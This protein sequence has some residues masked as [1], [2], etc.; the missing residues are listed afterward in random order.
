MMIC[1]SIFLPIPI[2]MCLHCGLDLSACRYLLVTH[3]HTDHF[4][5]TDLLMRI[6]GVFAHDLTQETITIA[7][8]EAVLS[9][10]EHYK[11]FYKEDPREIR[12]YIR[13]VPLHADTAR[14]LHGHGAARQ[15]Y[16]G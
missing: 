13:N 16:A 2:I 9:V 5:P 4:A 14:P 8:S 7:A 10:W 1:S 6:K 12:G 3:S 15:P 11:S